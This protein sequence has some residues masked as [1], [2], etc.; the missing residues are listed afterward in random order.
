VT[1]IESSFGFYSKLIRR[2]A[3]SLCL[4][5]VPTIARNPKAAV[6]IARRL[7][8][9]LTLS[10]SRQSVSNSVELTSIAVAEE[11]RGTKTAHRLM[12]AFKNEALKRGL[13]RIYL[14]TDASDNERAL[15]FYEK[16]GF[17]LSRDYRTS[18][19]RQM[20]E[21]VYDLSDC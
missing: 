17:A 4:S 7:Q 6:R 19:G 15:K 21:L 13:S 12:D 3:L 18:E 11:F 8:E 10:E 5:L 2:K 14:E 20:A 1:G 9:R 16:E